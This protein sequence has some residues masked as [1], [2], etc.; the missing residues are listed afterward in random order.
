MMALLTFHQYY[1]TFS[2]DASSMSFIFV[3]LFITHDVERKILFFL[4]KK[5]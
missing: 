2:S 1:L 5:K 4:K 3:N